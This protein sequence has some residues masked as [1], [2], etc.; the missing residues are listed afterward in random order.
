MKEGQASTMTRTRYESKEERWRKWGRDTENAKVSRC[1]SQSERSKKERP[2]TRGV[3]K[4]GAGEAA[5]RYRLG[6][7]NE[8]HETKKRF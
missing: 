7:K 2:T 4:D 3:S 1:K 6:R 5:A 8:D